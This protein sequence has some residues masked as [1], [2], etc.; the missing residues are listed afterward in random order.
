MASGKKNYFRHSFNARNDEFVIELINEFKEKG[1]FMW[2]SLIEICAEMVADGH[3]QPLKLHRSRL[4]RELRCNESTLKVFLRYC[5]GRSKVLHTYLE[6]TFNLEIPN[7]VKYVGKYSENAPNKRKEKEIKEKEIINNS[8]NQKSLNISAQQK[9]SPLS[10]LFSKNPD[11]Q[12]WLNEGVHETHFLL[13]KKYSHHVLVDLVEKAYA[14]AA[15]RSIRAESWLYTFVSNKK[16]HGFGANQAQVTKK[17]A[18]PGNPTGN[19]Y[20]DDFG[21][22]LEEA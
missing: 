21:Q 6:P 2:F 18:T 22:V 20:L 5:E 10:F 3:N 8:N 13:L 9:Q 4:I 15:P 12:K 7:L 14:W 16:T 19:P 17:R 1:Y 11:I